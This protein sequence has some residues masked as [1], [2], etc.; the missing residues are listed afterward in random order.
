MQLIEYKIDFLYSIKLNNIK[1]IIKSPTKYNVFNMTIPLDCWC[2]IADYLALPFNLL[3]VCKNTQLEVHI[4]ESKIINWEVISKRRISES[5]IKKFEQKVDWNFISERQTLS[6]SF[7][8]E[9]KHIVNWNYISQYQKLSE[10]F[11][12]E[13]TNMIG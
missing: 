12:R 5:F 1:T 3:G 4:H 2:H 6:E 11:T 10:S 9:F 13:F 7:I 8:R